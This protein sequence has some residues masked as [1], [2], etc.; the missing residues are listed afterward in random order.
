MMD[1]SVFVTIVIVGVLA[2]ALPGVLEWVEI[3]RLVN[4]WG[5]HELSGPGVIKLAVDDC[6][7][8]GWR[9]VV[10]AKGRMVPAHVVDCLATGDRSLRSLGLAADVNADWLNHEPAVIMLRRAR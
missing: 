5:L 1:P 6:R 9:G 10:I 2:A 4:G 8:L 3:N 7:L